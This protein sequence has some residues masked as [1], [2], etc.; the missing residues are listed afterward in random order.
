MNQL[1]ILVALPGSGKSFYGNSIKK[2]LG[3]SCN[4]LD[5]IDNLDSLEESLR[6][7]KTTIIADPLLTA[8]KTRKLSEA[9][10]NSF[11]PKV[12]I[13]WI[14]WENNPEDAWINVKKRDDGRIISQSFLKHLSSQ[15]N[16]P[17]IDFKVYKKELK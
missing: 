6:N 17:H 10:L 5:D 14:F 12:P 2:L 11:F 13:E 8:D 4:F 1:I 9:Y 7:F 16:P 3:T 15:Y